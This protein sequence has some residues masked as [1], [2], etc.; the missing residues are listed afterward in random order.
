GRARDR[1]ARD[2]FRAA[3]AVRAERLP[4][5]L[6]LPQR[7]QA[8]PVR[9]ALAVAARAVPLPAVD[10]GIRDRGADLARGPAGRLEADVPGAAERAALSSP[11]GVHRPRAPVHD[12]APAAGPHPRRAAGNRPRAPR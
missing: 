10:E 6:D 7:R 4:L 11:N 1:G 5:R 8:E 9:A 2:A 12:A 3:A